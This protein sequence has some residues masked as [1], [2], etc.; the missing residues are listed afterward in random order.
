[1]TGFIEAVLITLLVVGGV[2]ALVVWFGLRLLRRTVA[3]GRRRVLQVRSY[4]QP[5]GPRREAALLRQQ[6][7][8]ELHAMRQAVA[9]S[10]TG[11]RMFRADPSAVL[12]DAAQLAA[13]LDRDLATIETFPDR[14]QQSTALATVTPQVTQLIDTIYSARQTVLRT[15][16]L[17]RDRDLTALS[18]TVSDEAE[19]LRNYERNRRDLTI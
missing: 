4:V 19:S 9:A 15:A 14:T 13:R 1:M 2:G 8:A 10:P 7:A 17:D 5:P 11:G 12:A 3:H 16:A 6:L 18:A